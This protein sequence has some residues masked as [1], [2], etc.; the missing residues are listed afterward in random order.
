MM[1]NFLIIGASKAGTTAL[2]LYLKQHPQIYM[3]PIKEPRFF[4]FE[5]ERLDFKGPA[6]ERLKHEIVTHIEDY[7]A[8]FQ[9]VSKERAV[10]EVSPV[11]LY[12]PKAPERI[13]HYIPDVKLIAVLRNPIERGYSNFLAQV[14]EGREPLTD[15]AQ[16]L[17]EE[18]TRIR[19]NW[20]YIWHYR[21]RGFYYTQLR[22]YFD[23]FDRDQIRVYLYD[24]WK[25]NNIMIL[26]E[27]FH[28][29]N[30]DDTVVPDISVRPNVSVIPR[31]KILHRYLTKRNLIM[32]TLKPLLP[33]RLRQRIL[34][35]LQIAF[36]NLMS[37]NLVRPRLSLEVRRQLVQEYREDILKL[38]DLIDRDLSKWL[39]P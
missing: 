36:V 11:Y 17:Q 8:L 16:A 1:P 7:Y 25:A 6:D 37:L 2:Y 29:L 26:Q 12:S 35:K 15:Y 19:N 27:I 9:G 33:R 32:S 34:A 14:R 5:D 28:F 24:D 21:Q 20:S 13:R 31:S 10:G 38:Q 39:E 30:V 3:S 23:K 22:R 18:E 4:A